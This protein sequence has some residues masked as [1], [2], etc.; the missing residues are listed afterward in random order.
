MDKKMYWA[1]IVLSVVGVAVAAY[2]TIYKWTSNDSMCLGSGECA[3]VN[4]SPYSEVYGIPVALVGLVGYLA[5]LAIL[6]LEPRQRFF[7]EQ[8]PLMV[9][10][11]GLAGFAFNIYLVYLEFY[12]IK[13]L[14]P[15][16]VVS[17]ITMTILFV[18]AVIRLVRQN[19]N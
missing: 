17:Q 13:A 15:F 14:C 19:A 8:G 7:E 12:V 3:T 11:M 6:W 10:G 18:L 4:A 5:I 1:S 16:C 2:M 9:F